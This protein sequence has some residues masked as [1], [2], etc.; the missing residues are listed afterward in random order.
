MGISTILFEN[1]PNGIS[2]LDVLICP[3]D[4]LDNYCIVLHIPFFPP[5]LVQF[6]IYQFLSYLS[7][8]EFISEQTGSRSTSRKKSLI[9][10]LMCSCREKEMKYIVRTLV[11]CLLSLLVI[12]CL[13]MSG[14]WKK[15]DAIAPIL[16][17]AYFGLLHLGQKSTDWSNDENCFTCVGPGCCHEFLYWLS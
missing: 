5:C 6:L 7:Y 4:G 16:S 12:G 14:L 8:K 13:C 1:R 2:I 10:N 11:R 15:E 17:Y 9:V 3:Y